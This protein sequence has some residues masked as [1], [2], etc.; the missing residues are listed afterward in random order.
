MT[1]GDVLRREIHVES[2]LN[3][4]SVMQTLWLK[5]K[6]LLIVL[7]IGCVVGAGLGVATTYDYN[8]YGTQLEFFVNPTKKTSA[9]TASAQDEKT[10]VL[11]MEGENEENSTSSD[12]SGT[13]NGVN[14]AYGKTL[15]ETMMLFLSTEVFAEELMQGM[16]NCPKEKEDA[17]GNI[18][19]DY[20]AYLLKVKN[21]VSF[22]CSGVS[23]DETKSSASSASASSFVYVKI[24]VVGDENQTFAKDLLIQVKDK[25][26]KA[27]ERELHIPDGY[28]GTECRPMTVNE[29]IRLLN[30]GNTVN[31][32]IRYAVIV[33]F[34]SLLVCA[35][36]IILLEKADKRFKHLEF[37]SEK[38]DLPILAV[39]PYIP[40]EDAAEENKNVDAEV[41]E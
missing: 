26:P 19:A 3:F 16:P 37:I 8:V 39:V 10:L 15:M 13:G 14:G 36:T 33:G 35:V 38:L 28:T 24:S 2:D 31:T 6:I 23:E 41:K 21:A 25:V 20:L 27:I 7:L 22:S 29:G 5:W 12:S 4:I 11:P 1:K 30:S 18:K 40:H 34:I 32:A 17:N 9:A